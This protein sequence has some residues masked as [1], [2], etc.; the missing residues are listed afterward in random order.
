MRSLEELS[1]YRGCLLHGGMRGDDGGCWIF[2]GEFKVIASWGM[3][4]D[5]VSVSRDDRCPTY[6]EM[7]KVRKLFFRPEETVM[8]LSV[9]RS[10]H[11][12]IH[13]YC[14]HWWRPQRLNIPMP[15]PMMVGPKSLS[16]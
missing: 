2:P 8:Q 4:W 3:D 14:L 15:P 11:I 10:Q 9:P 6:E 16:R 1:Q 13:P 5:H 7:E 12:N